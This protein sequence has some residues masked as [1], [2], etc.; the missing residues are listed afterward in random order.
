MRQ[1]RSSSRRT[2]AAKTEPEGESDVL[3]S[4]KRESS[5]TATAEAEDAN[6][7]LDSDFE[8]L[9]GENGEPEPAAPK[10]KR[11]RASQA[12]NTIPRK[13][14]VR[15]K[16]GR[17]EGLMKMPIDIF[18]EIALNLMPKEIISLARA[19]KS[20]RALLMT[21]SSI[22][23]W[24]GA[25]RNVPGL[26]PCPPDMSEPRY[27]ALVYAPN[28]SMCGTTSSRR[29]DE[30]LRVRL[31]PSCRSKHLIKL[32]SVMPKIIAFVPSS[33]KIVP[34]KRRRGWERYVLTSDAQEVQAE[35]EELEKTGDPKILEEWK[36]TRKRGLDL[37]S[38]QARTLTAF[39]DS[40]DRGRGLELVDLKKQHRLAVNERL[41]ESGWDKDD[42]VFYYPRS[43]EW[44]SLVDQ[45]KVLTDRAW[46]NLQPKLIPL[47]EVNHEDR[48][49]KEKSERKRARRTRLEAYL[50]AIKEEKG[51]IIDVT[52]PPVAIPGST[53]APPDIPI[54]HIGIFP[55]IADALEWDQMKRLLEDDMPVAHMEEQV[56][57]CLPD[58]VRRV[59]KWIDDVEGHLVELL[60]KGR[61]VDNL[62]QDMLDASLPVPS[63]SLGPLENTTGNEKILLRADSLFESK[64]GGNQPPVVYDAAVLN[65]YP[66][67]VYPYFTPGYERPL[68]VAKLKPHAGAQKA[69]RKIL[70]HVGKPD[71]IFLEMKAP[72]YMYRCGR[73]HDWIIGQVNHFALE[74][75][76]WESMQKRQSELKNKGIA[77]RNVHDPA[78]VMDKPVIKL[79]TEAELAAEVHESSNSEGM[80]MCKVCDK[81][82][83]VPD[84]QAKES[85]IIAHLVD[86]HDIS[87]PKSPE[88]YGPVIYAG[89]D[90]D[91]P[92]DD[93]EDPIYWAQHHHWSEDDDMYDDF[94]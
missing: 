65:G 37:R 77:F 85:K 19:N 38:S 8:D 75:Q 43:R 9:K 55:N 35:W 90:D 29:M 32:A 39:L 34:S 40:L 51:P 20:F 44:S 33:N 86:V 50:K 27:L 67:M 15:G 7:K 63:A 78:F 49:E 2:K 87:E 12:T 88:H 21:K 81:A 14:Q 83:V 70:A 1:T 41:L 92:V 52:I 46:V 13:K 10:R 16:Q 42:L 48:L 66:S 30:M 24:H 31:C 47:L 11:A 74:Q 56:S 60:R 18:T 25:M 26:P 4:S 36:G 53:S 5:P 84:V 76:T 64:H 62:G 28:C 82:G 61:E 57:Q 71:A 93:Y 54:K 91:Y 23:I 45:A 72:G 69:A 59:D 6:E 73:C 58:I 89:Y 79:M 3:L 80:K 68:D 22:H 17:L 94:W